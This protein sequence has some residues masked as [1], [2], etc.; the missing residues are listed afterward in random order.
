MPNP[1]LEDL[2][3]RAGITTRYCDVPV[4]EA[5]L[6][7]ILKALSIDEEEPLAE[8]L[9]PGGM[10]LPEAAACHLPEWLEG[11]PAWGVFCQ[12]YELR[13]AR[14]WGIGDFTDLANLARTAAA[15]GA[16]FLGINPLH[17]LF[18][19]APARCSPFSPSNRRFLNPLYIAMDDLPGPVEAPE[20]TLSRLN[21][22]DR[23]DYTEVAKAKLTGLRQVFT[24]SPFAPGNY[25]EDAFGTFCHQGGE[26]LARHALFE[27]LSAEMVQ[28]G[29]E[30]GWTNWPERYRTVSS[31]EVAAFATEKA[32]DVR[33]HL[34]LQWISARQLATAHEAAQAA[35]MRIGLYLDMAVGEVPDGSATWGAADFTLPG[36]VIGAPPDVFTQGGQNWHLA[37]P[38]PRAMAQND[39]APFRALIAA[40][41]AHA[42]ALR[43]DHAMALWQL[44]LIPDDEP[45]R[46]GAHLRYPSAGLMRALAEESRRHRTVIIGED[47]GWVPPGFREAMQAA[48]L[49][50]YRIQY[51]EQ[52]HGLFRR[53]GIFP[54]MALACLSTHDLP[55]L[56]AW[57]AGEDVALRHNFGLIDAESAAE[58]SARRADERRALVAAFVDGGQLSHG[59]VDADALVLPAQ[60][61]SA[62][63]RFLAET[64]C[65]LTGVRLAD[66]AGPDRATNVPGTV[67]EYPNWRLR[68][69]VAVG[70]LPGLRAFQDVTAA[71]HKIRPRRA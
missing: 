36:L 38:A 12:L 24:C 10:D 18:T 58:Q 44:F 34:W 62:A 63:Y 1:N 15:A 33:F 66:L 26:A 20:Q 47:L 64:P 53:S 6:R 43:I 37:A 65:L 25:S 28:R 67:T 11:A 41:L 3:R 19:A 9:D 54:R 68:S 13:S 48:R 8:M 39:F 35:G 70:D 29:H 55:T 60:M 50:A 27:A 69:T 23:V 51:F 59:E 5:T 71:M 42:G 61:L 17:A 46:N 52:E 4:P 22:T 30:A 45:A 57:W 49:L 40:Q 56:K 16:D 32:R 21:S 14:Q 31:P 7:T 2:C